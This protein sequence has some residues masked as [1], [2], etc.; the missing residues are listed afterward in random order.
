[1]FYIIV[2]IYVSLIISGGKFM[3]K[4]T[5]LTTGNQSSF[6]YQVLENSSIIYTEDISFKS[7]LKNINGKDYIII[8]SPDLR[9]ISDAFSFLNFYKENHAINSK[10]KSTQALKLLFVF[11][12]IIQK[13]LQDFSNIDINNLK[14]FLR[15]IAPSG[16]RYSFDL[17]TIRRNETI[18]GYLAVY[19]Q[20]LKFLNIENSA[21]MAKSSKSILIPYPDSE[22]DYSIDK[23]ESNEKVPK[24]II[25]VPWYISV[26]EFGKIIS[27]IRNHYSQ[28]EEIIVRLMFQCGLRIG[29]VL[30]LTGEDLV[31]EKIEDEFIPVAYIRN[32]LSDKNDQKAKT[33]MKVLSK[34]DY[35]R[36][37]YRTFGYGFQKIIVPYDLFELINTYIEEKHIEARNSNPDRYFNFSLADKVINGKN[38]EDNYYVFLNT[39]YKP[40]TSQLWNLKLRKIFKAVGIIV[41]Q[42]I[43]KHNLNHRF[44]HGFAM[45]HVQHLRYK[46]VELKDRM[47]HNSIASV[48]KYYKPTLSDSIKIKTNFANNLYELIPSLSNG[49]Y[50]YE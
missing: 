29:E 8:Y 14:Y 23:Y 15:G 25:E 11:E 33:C 19:R 34:K 20:Y 35:R 24:K 7:L 2:T 41:D 44:R 42:N 16:N 21:L 12:K 4:I 9:T 28:L 17:K 45:F 5:E 37:E 49:E 32:R 40:L 13:K 27:E 30:G 50:T 48:S 38:S 36:K 22:V 47:R 10:I 43:R 46:S 1:M 18:N 6:I 31:V 3:I 39:Q 26:E